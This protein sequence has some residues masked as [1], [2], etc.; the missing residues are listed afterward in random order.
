MELMDDFKS[1]INSKIYKKWY[2]E[3]IPER[4]RITYKIR[5]NIDNFVKIYIINQ[6]GT[7]KEEELSKLNEEKNIFVS[8]MSNAILVLRQESRKIKNS[9]NFVT[10]IFEKVLFIYVSTSNT[11]DTLLS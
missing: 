1:T 7:S 2:T 4:S 3:K 6:E 5:D 9:P 8:H 10:Y 11:E